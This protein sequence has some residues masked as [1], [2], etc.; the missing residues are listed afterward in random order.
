MSV[1]LS[2]CVTNKFNILCPLY[3]LRY[4]LWYKEKP[5]SYNLNI[6]NFVATTRVRAVSLMLFTCRFSCITHMHFLCCHKCS[7]FQILHNCSVSDIT[8]IPLFRYNK[9][10]QCLRYYVQAGSQQS[11]VSTFSD[12]APAR[13]LIRHKCLFYNISRMDNFSSHT[14]SVSRCHACM[15]FALC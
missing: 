14:C 15:Q 6:C 1:H 9:H 10:K 3:I 7:V 2:G 13:L 4:L 11:Q 12:I 8:N 5:V